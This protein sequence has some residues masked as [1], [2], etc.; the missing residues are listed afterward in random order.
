VVPGHEDD[1]AVGSEPATERAQDRLGD[2]H[3][4]S[5]ASSI[6]LHDV[7]EQHQA[8][9]VPE[10]VEQ[11]VERTAAGQDISPQAHSEMEI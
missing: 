8:V 2:G 9:D 5:P 11:E 10:L 3:G 1:L 6:Q 7:T 4:P